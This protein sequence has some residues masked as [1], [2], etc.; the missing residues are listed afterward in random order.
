MIKTEG[1]KRLNFSSWVA[2]FAVIA[3]FSVMGC[4]AGMVDRNVLTSVKK[5][6]ILSISINKM[7]TQPTDD[8]VMLSI[9]NYAAP[10]YTDV[11]AKRSGME[12]FR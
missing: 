12:R 2:A 10:R 1:S 7:G 5:V 8:E 3:V 11:L 4:A 9:I 6:G